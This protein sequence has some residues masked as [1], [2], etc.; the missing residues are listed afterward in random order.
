MV[1]ITGKHPLFGRDWLQQLGI[2]LTALVNQSAIQMHQVDQQLS[3]PDSFLIEYADIFE[4][5]LGLLRDIEATVTVQQSAAPRFHKYR[6]VPFAV[7]E[8]VEEALQ[9]QV[10]EGQLIPVERSEWAAPIVVVH[11][12]MVESVSVETLRFQSIL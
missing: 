2:D 8:K 3:E 4:R 9:S 1:D 10:A 6:P 11:K 5:E 12:K 7:K